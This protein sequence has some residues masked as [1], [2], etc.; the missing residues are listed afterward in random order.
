MSKGKL[1]DYVFEVVEE[2]ECLLWDSSILE[3]S[4]WL[5]E[6]GSYM[7]AWETQGAWISRVVDEMMKTYKE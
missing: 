6:D 2:E 1:Y 4:K 7:G 5:N 3:P